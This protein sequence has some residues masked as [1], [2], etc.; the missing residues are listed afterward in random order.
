MAATDQDSDARNK[1]VRRAIKG[2]CPNC[3]HGR[4]FKG[5]VALVDRCGH[6]GFDTTRYSAGD[7]PATVLIFVYGAIIVP[8][9]FLLESFFAP[10]LWVHVV[11]WGGVMLAVTLLSLRMLKAWLVALQFRLQTPE[12]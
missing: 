3:G 2:L 11:L 4:L 9:A 7:A 8:L 1:A 12:N 5:W 6:C 10:P